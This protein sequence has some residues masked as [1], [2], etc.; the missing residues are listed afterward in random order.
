VFINYRSVDGADAARMIANALARRLGERRVFRDVQSIPPGTPYAGELLDK[1]RSVKVLLVLVGPNWEYHRDS[2]GRA[3][4]NPGDWVRREIITATE[5]GVRL[6][7]VLIGT[8]PKLR[9]SNLPDPVRH[10]AKVEFCH[11]PNGFTDVHTDE[12]VK[13]LLT[14]F[15]ELES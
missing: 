12:V 1:A 5:A 6:V 7:P 13:Q 3:I 2:T 14:W 10:L 11:L 9:E 15:P 4:D 8:R